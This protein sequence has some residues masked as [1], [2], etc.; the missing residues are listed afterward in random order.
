MINYDSMSDA[1]AEEDHDIDWEQRRLKI[2][3]RPRVEVLTET[4]RPARDDEAYSDEYQDRIV[5]SQLTIHDVT[6]A[7][8]GNYTCSPS[9]A[10]PASMLVFVSEGSL[11][12]FMLVVQLLSRIAMERLI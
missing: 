1:V 12:S 3:H 11:L 4:D 9:N 7:D 5:Y 10:E 8:S 2:R 6:D